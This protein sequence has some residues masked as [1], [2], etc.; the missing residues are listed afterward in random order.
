MHVS[1]MVQVDLCSSG[2]PRGTFLQKIS[3]PP[4]RS[5]TDLPVSREHEKPE[6]HCTGLLSHE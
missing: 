6:I 2:L 1:T 5:N 4:F 3:V